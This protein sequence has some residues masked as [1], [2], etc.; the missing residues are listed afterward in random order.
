VGDCIVRNERLES[1]E[2]AKVWGELRKFILEEM[3]ERGK[4]W[5]EP[6]FNVVHRGNKETALH[7]GK[8][9]GSIEVKSGPQ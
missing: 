2:I 8:G 3:A 5:L 7:G 9:K 6:T 4:Q 1:T